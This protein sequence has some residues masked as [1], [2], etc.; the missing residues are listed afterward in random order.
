MSSDSVGTLINLFE[1]IRI[2]RSVNE[3]ID[4]P[5]YPDDVNMMTSTFITK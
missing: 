4:T 5:F 1:I 3:L 2:Q